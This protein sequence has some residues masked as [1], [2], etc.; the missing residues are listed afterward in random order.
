M[1]RDQDRDKLLAHSRYLINTCPTR[2]GP[3]PCWSGFPSMPRCRTCQS[4]AVRPPQ[5]FQ[6]DTWGAVRTGLWCLWLPGGHTAWMQLSSPTRTTRP[7]GPDPTAAKPSSSLRGLR[8]PPAPVSFTSDGD[9]NGGT[10]GML[11]ALWGCW[12]CRACREHAVCGACWEW[13]RCMLGVAPAVVRRSLRAS[14]PAG[15]GP[16]DVRPDQRGSLR[17][18]VRERGRSCR[19]PQLPHREGEGPARVRLRRRHL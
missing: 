2:E 7:L 10:W 19:H 16:T 3:G 8:G 14:G 12:D 4:R 15:D 11:G 6:A 5:D 1:L 13:R 9:E 18:P 17:E